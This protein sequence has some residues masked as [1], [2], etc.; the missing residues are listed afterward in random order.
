VITPRVIESSVPQ[1]HH[2][3]AKT[4]LAPAVVVTQ[5]APQKKPRADKPHG[6]R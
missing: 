2:Y 3:G 4:G 6:E 5:A 1:G